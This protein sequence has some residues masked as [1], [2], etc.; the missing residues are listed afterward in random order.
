MLEDKNE[1]RALTEYLHDSGAGNDPLCCVR[2][3]PSGDLDKGLAVTAEVAVVDGFVVSYT[4]PQFVQPCH[5][6]VDVGTHGSRIR[7]VRV[8]SKHSGECRHPK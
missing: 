1:I 5:A 7:R 2:T 8:F 4:V 6:V 3:Y